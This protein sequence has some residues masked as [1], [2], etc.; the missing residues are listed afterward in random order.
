MSILLIGTDGAVG[1]ALVRRLVQQGD[2]VRVLEGAADSVSWGALG[3]YIA[4]GDM[5]DADLIER[6]AQDVRTIILGP[7]HRE[8]PEE[9]TAAVVDGGRLVTAGMRVVVYAARVPEGI[10]TILRESGLDYVALHTG[11]ARRRA[12]PPEALA[13]ALDAADDLAGSLRLELDLTEPASW[14]A[15]RLDAPRL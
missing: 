12:V 14:A 7:G 13:E 11:G 8:D 6:A 1:E 2:E 9:L 4:S 15:L 10:L 5:W 3:A